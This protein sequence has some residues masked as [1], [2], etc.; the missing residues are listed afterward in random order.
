MYCE[1][2]AP[3]A[4]PQLAGKNVPQAAKVEGRVDG[5]AAELAQSEEFAAAV[6]SARAGPYRR[7]C[8]PRT[9]RTSRTTSPVRRDRRE[10][11]EPHGRDKTTLMI[12]LAQ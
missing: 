12:R 4:V 5:R 2:A 6:A 7:M 3:V 1:G 9:S 10:A 11:G 8:S